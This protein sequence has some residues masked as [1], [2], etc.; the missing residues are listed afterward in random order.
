ML[1]IYLPI[2]EVSVDAIALVALGLVAGILSGLFGIGGGFILT[3]FLIFFGIP[4][5]IAVASQATQI[6][7]SSVSGLE[8]QW[9]R[10]S[11]D[12]RMGVV[13]VIGGFIGSTGGVRLFGYLKDIGQIDAVIAIAYVVLLSTM[14]WLMMVES[15]R[16]L[17]RKRRETVARHKLHTHYWVHRWPLKMRFPRSR[18]YISAILPFM[19]GTGVGVLSAIL[20]VGG[21]FVLIPIMIYLLGMPTATV[22][23][24]S[25]MQ[26]FFVAVNATL[27][28]AWHNQTVDI[29]LAALLIGGA[30]IGTPIGTRLAGRLPAEHLRA[31]LA[32][33]LIA[34]SGKLLFDLVLQPTEFYT[35]VD[36]GGGP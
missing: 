25:L 13:L 32:A 1:E 3:P 4:P 29:I 33:L 11:I 21:G 26:V 28:Q 9:R 23:G 2:A 27:L 6:I 19:I 12:V 15:T 20:G 10:R 18:L 22:I 5:A 31:L 14:G 35:L 30:V 24:T 36:P 16:T 7:A 34:M 17:W 8:A